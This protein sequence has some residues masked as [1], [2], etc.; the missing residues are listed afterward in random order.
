LVAALKTGSRRPAVPLGAGDPSCN[1][2]R[3]AFSAIRAVAATWPA[4]GFVLSGIVGCCARPG[5]VPHLS[6]SGAGAAAPASQADRPT[7][8]DAFHCRALRRLGIRVRLV[9]IVFCPLPLQPVA[10]SGVPT[11]A[12]RPTR[13]GGMRRAALRSSRITT[14]A[15]ACCERRELPEF[16]VECGIGPERGGDRCDRRSPASFR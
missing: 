3:A 13:H 12:C 5:I 16:A 14:S 7:R 10:Q 4:P 11:Q 6:C 9:E 1:N 15:A 8:F 2:C